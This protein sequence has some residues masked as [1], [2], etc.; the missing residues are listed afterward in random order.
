LTRRQHRPG[1]APA[2]G[3]ESH[4]GLPPQPAG[5]RAGRRDLRPAS[6]STTWWTPRSLT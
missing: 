2:H 1:P 6:R 5:L 4:P 3:R